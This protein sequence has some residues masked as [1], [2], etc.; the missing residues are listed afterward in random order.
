MSFLPLGDALLGACGVTDDNIIH[1]YDL[2]AEVIE[3]GSSST[4]IG[5]SADHLADIERSH[6]LEVVTRERGNKARAAKALGI[7]RR[8]LYRL[9]EKYQFDSS[10]D[11]FRTKTR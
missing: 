10:G 8:S 9:L 1:C 2:P 11:L 6:V 3:P 7:N 5:H 4:S